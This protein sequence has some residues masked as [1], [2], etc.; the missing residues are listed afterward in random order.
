MMMHP[1][2]LKTLYLSLKKGFTTDLHFTESYQ[3]L[4][5]RAA[6]P[7]APDVA[8]RATQSTVNSTGISNITNVGHFQWHT[9]DAIP[10]DHNF[11]SAITATTRLISTAI[12]PYLE[13]L[14]KTL[15]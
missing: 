13:R 7:M 4:W 9:R 6:A 5:Y 12:T 11:S 3:I 2:Q 10:A 14:L 15:T 1:E 8:G